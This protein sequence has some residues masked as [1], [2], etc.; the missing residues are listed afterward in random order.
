MQEKVNDLRAFIS[1]KRSDFTDEANQ[2]NNPNGRNKQGVS[3][4]HL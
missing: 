3:S 2:F 4:F 1:D